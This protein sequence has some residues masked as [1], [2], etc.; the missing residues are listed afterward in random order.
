MMPRQIC[1]LPSLNATLVAC[2]IPTDNENFNQSKEYQW[3]IFATCIRLKDFYELYSAYCGTK[4]IIF[5]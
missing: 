4:K 5:Y 3:P 2:A 1:N